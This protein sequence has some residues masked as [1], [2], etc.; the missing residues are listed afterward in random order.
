MTGSTGVDAAFQALSGSPEDVLSIDSVRYVT[1]A[2]DSETL[3]FERAAAEAARM[4]GGQRRA[5]AQRPHV[6]PWSPCRNP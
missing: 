2:G 1:S 6:P 5:K 4:Q 3:D